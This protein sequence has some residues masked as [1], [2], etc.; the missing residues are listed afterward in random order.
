MGA[1]SRTRRI[2]AGGRRLWTMTPEGESAR[3]ITISDAAVDPVISPDG[4]WIAFTSATN[5]RHDLAGANRG[6]IARAVDDGGVGPAEH[7]A[8]WP[9]HCAV[10]L[11]CGIVDLRC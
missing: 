3:E 4:K 10:P 6:R 1:L 8:G 5:C 2:A 11:E 9:A 7:L